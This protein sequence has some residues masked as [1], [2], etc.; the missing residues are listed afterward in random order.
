MVLN[1]PFVS[2]WLM[3]VVERLFWPVG[4]SFSVRCLCG[5][6]IVIERS[7]REWM[8]GLSAGT[9]KMCREVQ[10]VSRGSTVSFIFYLKTT[11]YFLLLVFDLR[12]RTPNILLLLKKD[13]KLFIFILLG[14]MKLF[15]RM[16]PSPSI[17]NHLDN[18]PSDIIYI[19]LLTL[20]T[21]LLFSKSADLWKSS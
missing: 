19:I 7:K 1:I 21:L 5:E 20:R 3:A 6:V 14:K 8:Y 9:K 16:T 2:R 4:T 13:R 15:V 17:S 11:T 12:L 10:A 18:L